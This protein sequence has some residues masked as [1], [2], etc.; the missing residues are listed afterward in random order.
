MTRLRFFYLDGISLTGKFKLTLEDLRWFCWNQCPLEC[1]PF[2][3]SPQ[4]LVILELPASK[5]TTMWEVSED[6]TTTPDFRGLTRLENLKTLNMS[7]S[8]DLTSTPDFRRLPRLQN[9]YLEGCRS[10]KEVHK[11]IGSLVRL[12]S[13]NLKDC[14]NLRS[15]PDTICNLG[16]LEVLCIEYCT[17]LKAL[18]I[19]LG[20]IKSLK[21]L[22]ASETS[23]PKLPDSIGDL[24]NLEVLKVSWVKALPDELGNIE[25]LREVRISG[26]GVSKL[27]DSIC[28]LRSLEI[29]D[30]SS[31]DTL[32]RLPDQLW[33]LT[34]LLELNACS[35]SRL[36]KVPDIESSQTSLPLTKLNLS[37]SNITAL[38]SGI[39]QLS[40]LE[41]L[42]LSKCDYLL[43][44][45]E[46]PPN[47]KY[48]SAIH[49]TSLERVNLS[50]LKLL[51]RLQ[52]TNCSA[53]TEILGLEEL[54]SLEYLHLLDCR[55]SLLT[56]TLTKPLFQIYS[57]FEEKIDIELEAEKFPDWI[58]Q[59]SVE[60]S[61]DDEISDGDNKFSLDLE[62]IDAAT[63]PPTLKRKRFDPV[64]VQ[65]SLA[66]SVMPPM[67]QAAPA[68]VPRR[69]FP[70]H[71]D[72]NRAGSSAVNPDGPVQVHDKGKAKLFPEFPV[73]NE[74][75][76]FKSGFNFLESDVNL[77]SADF[78]EE[79][80][81]ENMAFGNDEMFTK[82]VFQLNV[83]GDTQIFASFLNE[84]HD[85]GF[86]TTTQ[87][88]GSFL[89]VDQVLSD[90]GFTEPTNMAV[91]NATG[92]KE[93]NEADVR[94]SKIRRSSSI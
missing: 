34:S 55:S 48:I 82:D 56:H 81:G 87:A 33:K 30:I 8:K 89:E 1:L 16:A 80:Q 19:E 21:E 57:G 36:E 75:A 20:N 14:V 26:I 49:C 12:V 73:D 3:F 23:F 83:D 66:N 52:L 39:S 54:T 84:T 77:S 41:R 70:K 79:E 24:K 9:L 59:S 63:P 22:N 45:T 53:L 76:I 13:L 10:L 61:A 86:L 5:L 93:E 44:I 68:F 88:P 18:P 78:F 62:V 46:L 71:L 42:H 37:N 67:S 28:N 91:E 15:L 94:T 43:S 47:L 92:K 38:P 17:G 4:K 58:I 64:E 74:N 27:P 6:L 90:M 35:A 65:T 2:D 51:R 11:S 85:L 40:N 72:P 69:D 25:S 60:C 31:S 7:F 32:V 50:N 29:L